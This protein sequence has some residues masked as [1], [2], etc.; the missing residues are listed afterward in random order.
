MGIGR[1]GSGVCSALQYDAI[2]R[3]TAALERRADRRDAARLAERESTALRRAMAAASWCW[4]HTAGRVCDRLRAFTHSISS[5][6]SPITAPINRSNNN[7]N[8]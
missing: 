7:A 5:T 8:D 1:T 4:N 2:A 3:R 6:A